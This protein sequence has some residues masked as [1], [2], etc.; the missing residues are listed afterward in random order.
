MCSVFG[1]GHSAEN[2]ENDVFSL[3]NRTRAA[4]WA[5]CERSSLQASLKHYVNLLQPLNSSTK[6][7][8]AWPRR[9]VQRYKRELHWLIQRA[10]VFAQLPMHRRTPLLERG[11]RGLMDSYFRTWA[12]FHSAPSL[13]I[14][15]ARHEL[16]LP[17]LKHWSPVDKWLYHVHR[18]A[19]H[20]NVYRARQRHFDLCL[21]LKQV[22]SDTSPDV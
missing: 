13:L 10:S 7:A 9:P 6:L 15:S 21:T 19:F 1:G 5:L 18:P 11:P 2:V 14:V 8:P 16:A 3:E 20:L 22:A 4:L 17:V 12:G